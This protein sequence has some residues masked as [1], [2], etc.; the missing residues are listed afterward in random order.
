LEFQIDKEKQMKR[1]IFKAIYNL[2]SF[3]KGMA[4]AWDLGNPCKDMPDGN[5]Y[6]FINWLLRERMIK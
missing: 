4:M 3:C 2:S 1:I 6:E 5:K